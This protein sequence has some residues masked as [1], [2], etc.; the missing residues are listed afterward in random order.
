LLPVD[1]F[2]IVGRYTVRGY[3]T[4]HAAEN[5]FFIRNDLGITIRKIQLEAYVG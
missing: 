2:A 5:G 3:T 1:Q 4:S